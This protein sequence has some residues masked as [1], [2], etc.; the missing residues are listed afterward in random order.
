MESLVLQIQ[1]Q[2]DKKLVEEPKSLIHRP[3]EGTGNDPSFGERRSSSIKQLRT[4]QRQASKISEGTE[5]FQKQ[6][7]Q[8]KRQSKL[9]DTLPTRV[10]DSQIG[11]FSH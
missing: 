3:K 5:R 11:T 2:K 10:K 4:V 8:R 7:R 6:S 9:A 1:D